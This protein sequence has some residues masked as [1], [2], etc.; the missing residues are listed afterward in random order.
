MVQTPATSK[1]SAPTKPPRGLAWAISTCLGVGHFP[2]ASGTIG[3]LA[4]IP[5]YLAVWYIAGHWGVLVAAVATTIKG[6]WASTLHARRLGIHDPGE[7]VIDEVA[8][9]LLT[10]LFIQPTL[11]TVTVGFFLFRALDVLK[12]W[13]ASRMESLPDGWGIMADDV[14]LGI[15]ANLIIHAGLRLWG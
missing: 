9:F 8:G 7:V 6:V 15:V 11:V 4:A 14:F 5:L 10:M 1:A 12:P 2:I 13:P 3:T